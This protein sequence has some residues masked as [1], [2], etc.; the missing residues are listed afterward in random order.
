M[1]GG[2]KSAQ[3]A[4]LHSKTEKPETSTL[5]W[6]GVVFQLGGGPLPLVKLVLK[7]HCSSQS[8]HHSLIYFIPYT[9]QCVPPINI[10]CRFLLY[11]CK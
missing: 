6:G 9:S 5:S 2:C 10:Y 8:H 11:F 1:L 4:N 7:Y 3:S